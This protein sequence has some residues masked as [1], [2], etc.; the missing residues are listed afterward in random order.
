MRLKSN[1]CL[2]RCK[3]FLSVVLKDTK[4]GEFTRVKYCCAKHLRMGLRW[5]WGAPRVGSPSQV[6]GGGTML[7]RSLTLQDAVIQASSPEESSSWLVSRKP[8]RPK[9]TP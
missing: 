3:H 4:I 7:L 8:R 9:R 5:L 1:V 2:R 6:Q